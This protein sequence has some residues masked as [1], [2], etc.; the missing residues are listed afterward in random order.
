MIASLF[1]SSTVAELAHAAGGVVVSGN[2]ATRVV[3]L[4]SDSRQA[5]RGSMF[6]AVKGVMQD[7]AGFVADALARGAVGVVADAEVAVPADVACVRVADCRKAK[8]LMAARFFGEP[9]RKLMAV[10]VTGTNGKTTTTW[11]MRS[12]AQYAGDKTLLLGTI[13]NEL[14][15]ESAPAAN[16]TPDPIEL[17][18]MLA[19][20]VLAGARLAVMEVSSHALEQDRVL[21]IGFR[22]AAF[23]NLSPEHLDFHQTLDAYRDA[24][25]RLFEAL[26]D[27][28]TAVL[29]QDDPAAA[30]YASRTKAR[31]VRYGMTPG[32][33]VSVEV[34]RVDI[35]GCSFALRTPQGR[36]DVATRM[37]G[38]HNLFNAMAA[39]ATCLALGYPLEAVRG[40]FELLKGV[41]GRLESVDCGQD[42]R[43]LVDFAHTEAAL[44]HVLETLRPLTKG[45]LITVFGCGGDRDRTKRPRMGAVVSE[46]SDVAYVT[47]DNPRTE[48]PLAII[49]QIKSGL[50]ATHDVVIEPD[51]KRAITAAL[52]AARGG[53]I[54]VIAGKGHEKVQILGD[55]RIPF[56]DV[57]TAREVLWS[58]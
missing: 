17:H 31:V 10:G 20:A 36:M 15:G 24:K 49:D 40:G 50:V 5:V 8:A 12:V 51:R 53:D 43:V 55:R 58:L 35:D 1:P 45:R 23:T 3:S 19:D 47:S 6:F 37:V 4:A 25:A 48:D 54:V 2:G 57:E 52:K 56:D 21:G 28:A 38:R 26:D 33:D 41:P 29:N 42:F 22:A 46:L 30:I 32:A 16:T 9:A 11:M 44:R 39:A 27:S 7:G 34:H 13:A 18:R 14:D